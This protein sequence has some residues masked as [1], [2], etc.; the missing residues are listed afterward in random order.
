MPA[1]SSMGLD[2]EP[3]LFSC[4]RAGMNSCLLLSAHYTA[5]WRRSVARSLA[6]APRMDAEAYE[7]QRK[8][9]GAFMVAGVRGMAVAD[10]P[11]TDYC[12]ECHDVSVSTMCER[13]R[14]QAQISGAHVRARAHE[15]LSFTQRQR[16]RHAGR[17]ADSRCARHGTAEVA[18]PF[19]V[20][21]RSLDRTR[22][23]RRRAAVKQTGERPR[24]VVTGENRRAL[25]SAQRIAA[26]L[27]D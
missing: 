24:F 23:E 10:Q 9:R 7:L 26:T 4:S 15:A 11:V 25:R 14:K 21:R 12:G 22:R 13:I 20:R 6:P 1:C 18:K 2:S 16:A 27:R 3:Q 17:N 5:P 8:L 19:C